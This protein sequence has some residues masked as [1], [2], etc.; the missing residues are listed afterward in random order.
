MIKLIYNENIKIDT[1]LFDVRNTD[2]HYTYN[3]AIS[4]IDFILKVTLINLNNFSFLVEKFERRI[5]KVD[6]DILL[7]YDNLSSK[8][9]K[10]LDV[11]LI[12]NNIEGFQL[13]FNVRSLCT[14]HSPKE[15]NGFIRELQIK[16]LLDD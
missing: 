15:A 12:D 10:C 4:K 1:Y 16:R 11:S 8:M 13:T 7:V 6:L 3:G 5:D 14:I 9:V 2:R